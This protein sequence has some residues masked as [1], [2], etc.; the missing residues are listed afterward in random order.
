MDGQVSVLKDW[1][2]PYN[3]TSN[4]TSTNYD[5]PAGNNRLLVVAIASTRNGNG[6]RRIS[7]ITYGGQPLSYA[8]GNMAESSYRAHTSI[9]YLD[10]AGIVA[11]GSNNT[12]VVNFNRDGTPRS[13]TV[14]ASVFQ[15]VD[16]TNPIVDKK[17]YSNGS[18]S[19]TASFTDFKI[20][21]NNQAVKVFSAYESVIAVWNERQAISN[22]GNG[23]SIN[24]E[25]SHGDLLFMS[26]NAV[27]SRDIPSSSTTDPATVTMN[28]AT[29]LSMSG[30]SIKAVPKYFR[31]IK[32]GNWTDTSTW[33]QSF[34]NEI[35]TNATSFPTIDDYWT[36]VKSK[37]T[38]TVDSDAGV[39]DIDIYGTLDTSDK[40]FLGAN[41][42]NLKDG[43]KLIIGGNQN[44]KEFT[45]INIDT[46]TTVE[47][48]GNEAQNIYGGVS[49]SNLV[50]RGSGI[51]RFISDTE[52]RHNLTVIAITNSDPNVQVSFI[53]N[54]DQEIEGNSDL[55]FYDLRVNKSGGNLVLKNSITTSVAVSNQLQLIE[56]H[57][58][59]SEGDLQI[60]TTNPGAITSGN[61]D[62]DYSNSHIIG[63]LSRD[64]TNQTNKNYIYPISKNGKYY[65]FYLNNPTI[66][67]E[68]VIAKVEAF[69]TD[70]GGTKDSTIFSKSDTEYWELRTTGNFT[71]AGISISRPD[72]ISPYDIA[73]GSP[74]K[75]GKYTALYGTPTDNK[76]VL[77]SDDIDSNRF[78][79]FGQ[80]APNIISSSYNLTGFTYSLNHGPS[81]IQS[82]EIS[83]DYLLGNI[84]VENTE[85]FEIS[86]HGD[87]AFDPSNK[88][89]Y[90]AVGPTMN[91][92]PLYIRLKS[93]LTAE[94][95]QDTLILKTQN[96][97]DKEVILHGIVT[98]APQLS[99]D[100]N[101]LHFQHTFTKCTKNN[102]A[103][104][105]TGSELVE[106]VIVRA[107][108]HFGISLSDDID[109]YQPELILSPTNGEL[110]ETIYI[111]LLCDNGIGLYEENIQIESLY[112]E[113]VLINCTGEVVP[114]PAIFNS[115]STLVNTIYTYGEG[116]SG[117]ESFEVSGTNLLEDIV[118]AAPITDPANQ[119]KLSLNKSDFYSQIT[120]PKNQD[121]QGQVDP[122]TIYL[123]LEAGLSPGIKG[124]YAITLSS[125][126]AQTKAI[127]VRGQVI[128][129]DPHINLSTEEINN[130]GYLVGHGPSPVQSLVLCGA[131]LDSDITVTAPDDYEI[132]LSP[133]GG[134]KKEIILEK[135]SSNRV[136]PTTIYIR[137]KAGKE[138]HTYDQDLS[139]Y[140]ENADP[141]TKLIPLTG[142]V[143]DTPEITASTTAIN[144]DYCD[145]SPIELFSSGDNITNQYWEGPNKF[146]STEKD[147]SIPNASSIMSG[148][149][150]VTG[151]IVIGGNL[152]F[153]GDFEFGNMGFSS[154]YQ[155][156]APAGN[157]TLTD[158]G[159]YSVCQN[160]NTLHDD[161]SD[162][163]D[164]TTGDGFQMIVNG[165][166]NPGT[167]IWEQS[168]T[169][170]PGADYE[171]S[172]FV[173]S[174][175]SLNPTKIQFYMDG[176]SIG[177]INQASETTCVYERYGY[178]VHVPNDV[179]IVNLQIINHNTNS[180]GNDFALDDIEFKQVL[181][182]TDSVDINVHPY[183]PV[184]LMITA[185]DIH[186]AKGTPVTFTAHP[187]NPGDDP[188]YMWYVND[189]LMNAEDSFIYVNSDLDD[190]NKIT[191]KLTSSYPC[192]E[193]N[194]NEVTSNTITISV[195]YPTNY[196]VGTNSTAWN[197]ATNWSENI[198]PSAGEN[199]NFH[200]DPINDLYLDRDRTVGSINNPSDKILVITT[201]NSLMVNGNI[202][203]N[204][205]NKI[206]IK[207]APNAPN[208]SL[209][210]PNV[211]KP[212]YATVEMWSKASIDENAT[213]DNE[214][215]N[216]QFF[217]PP[218]HSYILDPASDFNMSAVR[219]YVEGLPTD[220][221][222]KQWM[223]LHNYDLIGKFGG[224]EI[225]HAKPKK[226]SFK[227][228]LV[229]EDLV[230]GEFPVTQESFYKGW[231]LISNPYT[232]AI[233]VK[234]IVFGDGMDKTIYLYNTGSFSD[235]QTGAGAG[236][237]QAIWN[238]NNIV[239]LGQYLAI[240][241]NLAGFSDITGVIPSM[242]G[243]MVSVLDRDNPA[244]TGKTIS[245]NYS[246]LVK[247]TQQQRVKAEEPEFVYSMVTITGKDN[248]DK[249]WLF[250]DKACTSKY[251]NGWDGKKIELNTN[252]VQMI[253]TQGDREMYQI[254]A[255]DDIND[256][257]LLVYPDKDKA[258]YTLHFKHINTNRIYETIQ[259]YD[260]LTKQFID[261]SANGSQYKFT[262]NKQDNPTRFKI[263][264]ETFEDKNKFI[265]PVYTNNRCIFV[266]NTTSELGVIHLFDI[267]GQ[268]IETK[269]FYPDIVTEFMLNVNGVF[270]V[271][272]E[273]DKRRVS[274]K[275]IVR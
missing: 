198:V 33:E 101:N 228:E 34:D 130:F 92:T 173:Q 263:I 6:T 139:I 127:M 16:Q 261:I 129:T 7:T 5:I 64:I 88:V 239:A 182:A 39:S 97:I 215:Y 115:V 118:I 28:K 112:A 181:I 168:V 155:Y 273:T 270:I 143:Y 13:N 217:G 149:Y 151:N 59:T 18:A 148:T 236:G 62:N 244:P 245:F 248:F 262:A 190:G 207:A 203:T 227:G 162:C 140:T 144:G 79:T 252:S 82:I 240:P 108:T 81:P 106:D 89:T 25:V 249:V 157:E 200:E 121:D 267:S 271:Q 124:P 156:K 44:I 15:N 264:T 49:Y 229:K 96:G 55:V 185:S 209:V 189:E 188:S 160:P 94:T 14:F 194:N 234:D 199:I 38:V 123:R 253:A 30:I 265:F 193:N 32:T 186:I 52:I 179:N 110:E 42:L 224:Y 102:Q 223:Q 86:K 36:T 178:I 180:N 206:L 109:S 201:G 66:G 132:S 17:Q 237:T 137:L 50:T 99:V 73:V 41:S 230:T 221:A 266:A 84:T 117:L 48:N 104:I 119:F 170:T 77:S 138:V 120:L 85:H 231:H 268:L 11:A 9:Y 26:D 74:S 269:E 214:K 114:Q 8:V 204:N 172:Y 56:G 12:L 146:Y 72:F 196:W 257:Y 246:N 23:W 58:D 205:K 218:T 75:T 187:T 232:A 54:E 192:A 142:K 259:L 166:G 164:N 216:W 40:E 98:G 80:S 3:G 1:E 134:Y 46:N 60:A 47:Y 20:N 141:E 275:V 258:E 251:D 105:I 225:T 167:I 65:E 226:I 69:D 152:V 78:F 83:G 43:G 147:V 233:N 254:H 125:K 163:G 272:V 135:S 197:L 242:Q 158:E 51:K 161:F 35:W 37:H 154:A 90:N 126:D 256:T 131:S 128:A 57:I 113:T 260:N 169:V 10:E 159:T 22:F 177:P 122:T 4:N 93:G 202:D 31:S 103:V 61:N 107:P 145:N 191:C 220:Q 274:Q 212:V 68:P 184:D 136:D 255:T 67:P 95:Y 24:K 150:S 76:S 222:G 2:I 213:N 195:E 241:Q 153:N 111:G 91:P 63:A 183:L 210:F 208:G 53:G 175:H 165:A 45:S 29:R 133:N 247:N 87:I 100:K 71:N 243:F 21:A 219:M 171:F 176:T 116:P 27:G 238:E 235:W 211:T 250:T 70:A 19:L 174:V